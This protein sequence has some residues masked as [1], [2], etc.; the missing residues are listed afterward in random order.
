MSNNRT[1]K[2]KQVTPKKE[3]KRRD[4]KELIKNFNQV[5]KVDN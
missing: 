2:D 1:I 4:R 5:Q 3:R